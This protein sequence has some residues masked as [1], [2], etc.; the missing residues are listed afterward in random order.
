MEKR[1]LPAK[2]RAAAPPTEQECPNSMPP[3]KAVC[4]LAAGMPA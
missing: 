3:H 2:L 1:L 4:P